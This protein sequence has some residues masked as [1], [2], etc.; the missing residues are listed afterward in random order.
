MTGFGLLPGKRSTAEM[1]SGS[2]AVGGVGDVGDVGG[3]S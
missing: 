1:A 3:E 2:T